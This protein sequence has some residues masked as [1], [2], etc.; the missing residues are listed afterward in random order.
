MDNEGDD[1]RALMMRGSQSLSSDN[2]NY[3]QDA[4]KVRSVTFKGISRPVTGFP[5]LKIPYRICDSEY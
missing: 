5:S 4:L 2:G 3:M 1:E